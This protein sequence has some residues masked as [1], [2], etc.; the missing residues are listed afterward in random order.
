MDEFL[1]HRDP[2]TLALFAII[3]FWIFFWKGLALWHAGRRDHRIWFVFLLVVSTFGILEIVY[4]FFVLK[5]KLNEL[6]KN[7]KVA[8]SK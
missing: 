4:L 1:S 5:L 6:F 3:A 2:K 8:D 7:E